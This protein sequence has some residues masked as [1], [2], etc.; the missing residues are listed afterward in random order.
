MAR[1]NDVLI[2][3]LMDVAV[4]G[5]AIIDKRK[6]L[7]LMGKGQDRPAVWEELVEQWEELGGDGGEFYGAEVQGKMIFFRGA[8]K[9]E[10]VSSWA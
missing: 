5:S 9:V 8:A 10:K 6:L 1:L 4:E 7:R 2:S 3:I